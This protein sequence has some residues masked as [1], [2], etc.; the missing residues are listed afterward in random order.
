M[1]RRRTV[2]AGHSVTSRFANSS[3]HAAADG[4]SD[5][6]DNAECAVC[7]EDDS[8]ADFEPSGPSDESGS[9]SSDDDD[10]G[11][12]NVGTADHSA[13]CTCLAR[14]SAEELDRIRGEARRLDRRYKS[15]LVAGLVLAHLARDSP[16]PSPP[17]LP[18]RTV[19]TYCLFDVWQGVLSVVS[20]G[21]ARR[22]VRW[23]QQWR[24][25]R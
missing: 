13:S 9:D 1:P 18:P 3:S 20:L 6:G 10:G 21:R 2:P 8:D 25:T 23:Q 16:S 11:C 17:P 22:V 12:G 5:S 14:F 15:G 4:I 7:G 24:Q 19:A